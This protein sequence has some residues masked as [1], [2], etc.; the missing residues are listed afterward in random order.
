M[1]NVSRLGVLYLCTIV[2][3]VF[4]QTLSI[5]NYQLVSSQQ[6]TTTMSLVTYKADIVNK[7]NPEA[8][9]TATATT[10][11]PSSF[12]MADGQD[13]LKFAPVPANAQ[14]TSSNTFSIRVN[15]TVTFDFA[16][17]SWSFQT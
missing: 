14:V 16:N 17:V 13:T 2:P 5:T 11:N 12:T 4:G 9:I 8:S 1:R 10:L 3:G 7:G 6:I 15:R